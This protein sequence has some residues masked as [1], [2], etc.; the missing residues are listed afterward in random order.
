M[1]PGSLLLS[2]PK[3]QNLHPFAPEASRQ[4]EHPQT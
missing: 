4:E 1:L 2:G 3:A